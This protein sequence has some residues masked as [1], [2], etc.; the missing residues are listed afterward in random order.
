MD[1]KEA[2]L[3]KTVAEVKERLETLLERQQRREKKR[4]EEIAAK[5]WPPKLE[6]KVVEVETK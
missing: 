1:E 6:T 5:T 4:L 3:I 2:E